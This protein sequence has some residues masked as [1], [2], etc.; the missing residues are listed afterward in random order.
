MTARPVPTLADG[1]LVEALSKLR[2][3]AER[4]PVVKREA[5]K[6]LRE[7]CTLLEA[8]LV[9]NSVP[10]TP[11]QLAAPGPLDDLLQELAH[12]LAVYGDSARPK[13]RAF[14]N[15]HLRGEPWVRELGP[16]VPT[17]PGD[18]KGWGRFPPGEDY[19][20]EAFVMRRNDG[21]WC[22]I[23]R[24][25][26]FDNRSE[27]MRVED[28]EAAAD[29]WL[30]DPALPADDCD[31]TSP[32]EP[33]APVE[34]PAAAQ[35]TTATAQGETYAI[36]VPEALRRIFANPRPVVTSYPRHAWYT[37]AE[38]DSG[39]REQVC[40][41]CGCARYRRPE[42]RRGWRYFE[43]RQPTFPGWDTV[44]GTATAG[45]CEPPTEEGQR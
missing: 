43:R 19:E 37:E 33:A 4:Q 32:S 23:G 31:D 16:W 15:E 6:Y 36:N 35:T 7:V 11:A 21:K 3:L 24:S 40:S 25:E 29:G 8:V 2:F 1:R 39:H 38:S 22:R 9:G 42:S 12:L 34:A 26:A 41:R 10:P 14:A 45:R 13:L 27:A 30:F 28:A 44:G 5:G 17:S 18:G 20:P